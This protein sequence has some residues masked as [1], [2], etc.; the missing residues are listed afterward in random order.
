MMNQDKLQSTANIV[1]V[2]IT[3]WRM[4]SVS[5]SP[6]TAIKDPRGKVFTDASVIV[7]HI[8]DGQKHIITRVCFYF[9][10][11]AARG[12][13]PSNIGKKYKYVPWSDIFSM[14]VTLQA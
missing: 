8:L 14:V 7:I 4:P 1:Q 10:N 3:I 5:L 2:L 11:T 9:K 13:S 12:Q 6:S